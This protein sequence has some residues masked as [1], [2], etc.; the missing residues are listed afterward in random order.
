MA[1]QTARWYSIGRLRLPGRTGRKRSL[2][3]RPA[4]LERLNALGAF[5]RKDFAEKLRPPFARRKLNSRWGRKECLPI[6]VGP[7]FG[8]TSRLSRKMD[9]KRESGLRLEKTASPGWRNDRRFLS[10]AT[11]R[12]IE[13]Q[14]QCGVGDLLP[15]LCR[16][17]WF[18]A[19]SRQQALS[20]WFPKCA[21]FPREGFLSEGGFRFHQYYDVAGCL[22]IRELH[23]G[24]PVLCTTV[25]A[26][27]CVRV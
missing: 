11:Q 24:R 18:C 10:W 17:S 19:V 8:D 9:E 5:R 25:F 13:R 6:P 12:H 15:S 16:E 20:R 4:V 22:N 14:R 23:P 27:D 2:F 1:N 21:R 7:S 26:D 3:P